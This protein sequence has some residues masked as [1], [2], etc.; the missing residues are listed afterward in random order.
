V[1]KKLHAD[2][3]ATN[4][5]LKRQLSQTAWGSSPR[6][7]HPLLDVLHRATLR[8][9]AGMFKCLCPGYPMFMTHSQLSTPALDHPCYFRA[10]DAESVT[11]R[12]RR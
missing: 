2:P 1:G 7:P 5:M 8:Q 9:P 11:G 4:P 12:E 3:Y 6:A 10:Q